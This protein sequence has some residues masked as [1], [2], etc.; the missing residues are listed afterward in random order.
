MRTI[1]NRNA[2]LISVLKSAVD[3]G[4][5]ALRCAVPAIVQSWDANAQTITAKPAIKE[6]LNLQGVESETEIPL[7]VDVPVVMPR[8]GG[9]G[10]LMVPKQG[11]ECLIVFSDMCIDAWWQSGGIQSQAERRRHDL[12]DGFAIMGVWSQPNK[13]QAFPTEGISLQNADGSVAITIDGSGCHFKG[14]DVGIKD[15][16]SN[17][18][19]VAVGQPT[20][21]TES[22]KMFEVA[23]DH[24][25]YFRGKANFGGGVD[26][27]A[28]DMNVQ[29]ADIVFENGTIKKSNSWDDLEID[30]ALVQMPDAAN[31]PALI[32]ER[33]GVA[34]MQGE[35]WL[36][37]SLSSNRS[38]QIATIAEMYRPQYRI[39]LPLQVFR[40]DNYCY[41]H[42]AALTINPDGTCI[43]K[44][45]TANTL[46]GKNDNCRISLCCSWVI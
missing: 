12:S 10:L 6:I 5:K 17:D 11:D 16:Y 23:E 46:F 21:A 42:T 26:V 32:T 34:Y 3:A 7:L 41:V 19:G 33:F 22:N 2:D 28:Q 14:V 1:S 43:L 29:D 37:S 38:I 9:F 45:E 39:T 40:T 24:S 4:T 25:S 27:Y 18:Y 13:P 36:N 31:A 44:N 30:T 35:I 15:L 8:A 20:T